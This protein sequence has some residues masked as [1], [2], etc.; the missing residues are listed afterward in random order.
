[1]SSPALAIFYGFLIFIFKIV[2]K[3]QKW[4]MAHWTKKAKSIVLGLARNDHF[5]RPLFPPFNKMQN[6]T[7]IV[8]KIG[9]QCSIIDMV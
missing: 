3:S 1:M 9:K 4:V 5:V 8:N 6:L 7:N 2:L